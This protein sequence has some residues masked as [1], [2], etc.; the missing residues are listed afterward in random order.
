MQLDESVR[1]WMA[2]N[3]VFISLK[4]YLAISLKKERNKK[5]TKANG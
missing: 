5:E 2:L 1:T 4:S 3:C